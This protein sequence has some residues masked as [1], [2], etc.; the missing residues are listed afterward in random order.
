MKNFLLLLV[1]NGAYGAWAMDMDAVC[2]TSTLPY[3]E[4]FN[5]Y[6][7][8]YPEKDD[9][10]VEEILGRHYENMIGV[11]QEFLT[12]LA[13]LRSQGLSDDDAKIVACQKLLVEVYPE[14]PK[15]D[16]ASDPGD[17]SSSDNTEESAFESENETEDTVID[18]NT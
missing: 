5:A 16:A 13:E 17:D 14:V 4:V 7:T 15:P 10:Q 2:Q 3:E 12:K 11:R 9:A 1:L 6:K 18:E 8:I